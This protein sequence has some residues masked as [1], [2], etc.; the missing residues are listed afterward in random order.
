[1]T[2]TSA[3]PQSPTSIPTRPTKLAI[4]QWRWAST[5]LLVLLWCLYL[6]VVWLASLQVDSPVHASHWM[7]W[8][9]VFGMMVVWP[10]LQLSQLRYIVSQTGSN[11]NQPISVPARTWVVFVQ[12]L[13]LALVNQSV[14]WPLQITANWSMMQSLWINA[15]LL[16]WSLLIGLFIAVGKRSIESLPRTIAMLICVGLLFG[17]PVL[18]AVFG[19]SWSM[20]ISPVSTMSQLLINQ[21]TPA[22]ATHITA[23]AL[24]SCVG[25]GILGIIQAAPAE[26]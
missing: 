1:M 3:L 13:C 9:M 15:A 21:V 17:E 14:L 18:Q 11:E 2:G 22:V 7:V 12:W 8:C 26:R 10:A 20:L 5:R 19:Q 16:A 4:R 23:V 24:A 6:F 25:W